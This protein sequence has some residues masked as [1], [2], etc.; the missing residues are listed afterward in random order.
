MIQFPEFSWNFVLS[1]LQ[2]ERSPKS[3]SINEINSILNTIGAFWKKK[4]GS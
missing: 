1:A 4:I 2:L 3:V